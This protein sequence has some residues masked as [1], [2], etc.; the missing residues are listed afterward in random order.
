MH[1]EKSGTLFWQRFQVLKLLAGMR[2]V[3]Q[4]VRHDSGGSCLVEQ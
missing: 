4:V 3:K 1:S 2:T